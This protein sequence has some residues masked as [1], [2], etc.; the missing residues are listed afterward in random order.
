MKTVQCIS[1]GL[2]MENGYYQIHQ[3]IPHSEK[4]CLCNVCFKYYFNIT[5]ESSPSLCLMCD[6]SLTHL[7]T[8]EIS[9]YRNDM[10]HE[11]ALYHPECFQEGCDIISQLTKDN[12]DDK[13]RKL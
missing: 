4:K 6:K 5:L 12:E 10:L 9:Y 13:L 1:C 8:W 3:D 7:K 11:Y 2:L